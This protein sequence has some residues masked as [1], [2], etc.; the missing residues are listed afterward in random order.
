VS[1]YL[2]GDFL[3][4]LVFRN[5]LIDKLHSIGGTVNYICMAPRG[6]YL[7]VLSVLR[8]GGTIISIRIRWCIA[9]KTIGIPCRKSGL[10]FLAF[11]IVLIKPIKQTT[12]VLARGNIE[13]VK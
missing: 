6:M 2:F 5:D 10:T 3:K 1:L 4:P 9:S 12:T 11:G 7:R 13:N 8:M